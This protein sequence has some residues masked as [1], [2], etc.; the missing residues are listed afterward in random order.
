MEAIYQETKH[1]STREAFRK[2]MQMAH[3][4]AVAQGAIPATPA[5]VAESPA[6]YRT[7]PTRK[8]KT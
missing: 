8:K 6:P 5:K 1:L 7:K 3:E 4:A 2:V